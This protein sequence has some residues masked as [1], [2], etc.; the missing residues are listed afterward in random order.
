MCSGTRHDVVI[1]I[2]VR[3]NAPLNRQLT[4][5]EREEERALGP[6]QHRTHKNPGHSA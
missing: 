6:N 2:G 3:S 1:L 4:V 5:G